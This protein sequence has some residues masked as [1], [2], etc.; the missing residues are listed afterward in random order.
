MWLQQADNAEESPMSS[1]PSPNYFKAW[2]QTV[3]QQRS[4][5]R[6]E[7]GAVKNRGTLTLSSAE[8]GRL[9]PHTPDSFTL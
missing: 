8:K 1:D 2:G 7:H 9:Q 5:L 4:F 6:D 3:G